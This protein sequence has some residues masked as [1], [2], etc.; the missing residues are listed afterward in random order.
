MR[1]LAPILL[2][3]LAAAPA[4]GVENHLVF[5]RQGGA[6]IE[7]PAASKTVAWCGPYDEGDVLVTTLHVISY[8][9][10][11]TD[12][13]YWRLWAIPGDVTIGEPQA[14]PNRWTW[15]NP[16]S[17]EI[18][19]GDP[20]NEAAT[21]TEESAGSI[22]FQE[23]DC[24]EGG[25]VAFTIDARAGSEFGDGPWV[26]IEGS[27]RATLTGSPFVPARASTWGEVKATYR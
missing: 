1:A 26:S 25:E 20:P 16:D 3:A 2:L 11:L 5:T 6:V 15:P 10:T 24:R 27:F 17:V 22:T 21:D 23:L 14:F 19:I 4:V 8:D 13:H 12:G 18:F 9:S 7:F